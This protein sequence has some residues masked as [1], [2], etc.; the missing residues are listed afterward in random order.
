MCGVKTNIVT[1]VEITDRFAADS[2]Y[3][4]PL[5]DATAQNFAMQEV[6]A[7]KAYSSAANLQTVVD[8]HSI[9][10]IPFKSNTAPATTIE[11]RPQQSLRQKA[12]HQATEHTVE[13]DVS[14]LLFQSGVV[15][16]AISQAQQRRNYIHMIKAKFGDSLRSKTEKHR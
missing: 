10:Y 14:L 8:H 5:V 3:F 9:P 15:L 2:N 16:P 1:A 13:A 4:K 6:S 11:L 7:D 12:E